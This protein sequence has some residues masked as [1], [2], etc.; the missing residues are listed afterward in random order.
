MLPLP[1]YPLVCFFSGFILFIFVT[2]HI[3]RD[4]STMYALERHLMFN[5]PYEIAFQAANLILNRRKKDSR[6][7]RTVLTLLVICDAVKLTMI[8][9]MIPYH[10]QNMN[11]NLHKGQRKRAIRSIYFYLHNTL[12]R[13]RARNGSSPK[14]SYKT[15]KPFEA[16]E[17]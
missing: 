14:V 16:E 7:I 13:K 12:A 2:W 3:F 9:I 10:L 1:T 4:R 17:R 8:L 15:S 11:K 6:P 5:P